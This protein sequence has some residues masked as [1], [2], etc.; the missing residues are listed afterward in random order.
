MSP[1]VAP[2]RLSASDSEREPAA[3]NDERCGLPESEDAEDDDE[4]SFEDDATAEVGDELEGRRAKGGTTGA[5][6]DAPDEDDEGRRPLGV[7]AEADS[8]LL[9]ALALFLPFF[10]CCGCDCCD[11]DC[12]CDCADADELPPRDRTLPESEAPLLPL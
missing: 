1:R 9:L 6:G 4:A 5:A 3:A 2:D 11:C 10:C 7:N 12:D 8:L